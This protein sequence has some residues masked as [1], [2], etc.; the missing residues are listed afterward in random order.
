MVYLAGPI[1]GCT[2]VEATDWRQYASRA[3]HDRYIETLDPMRS[4]HFLST[5]K[6]SNDFNEYA[7]RGAFY[8]SKGIMTRDHTDVMRCDALLVNLLGTTKPSLGTVMEL[9][10]AYAY[11]KPVVVAIEESGNPHDN[12][13]MLHEAMTF[14]V[15]T[16]EDAID[17]VAVILNR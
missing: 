5:V 9:A 15:T 17:S 2:G 1:A 10:W 6:I 13:P 14:R 11:K 12:H 8:T 3:L 16:L 7:M 4:K